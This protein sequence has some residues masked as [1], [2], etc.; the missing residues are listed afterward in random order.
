MGHPFQRNDL[1]HLKKGAGF[2]KDL[3][4]RRREICTPNLTW[5][6]GL[7]FLSSLLLII[8]I[9][10]PRE[11]VP[12]FPVQRQRRLLFLF[13]PDTHDL[14]SCINEAVNYFVVILVDGA[15][16]S[17]GAWR[18]NGGVDGAKCAFPDEVAGV[19]ESNGTC[20]R[21]GWG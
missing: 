3:T 1:F 15:W 11:E 7:N 10:Q 17:G 2:G 13:N 6:K 8:E 12:I 5:R 21:G 4:A 20:V 9:V 14:T 19:F 16:K 18:G